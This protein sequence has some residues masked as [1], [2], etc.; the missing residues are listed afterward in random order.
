MIDWW[1]HMYYNG[2]LKYDTYSHKNML[3][4]I[5][6]FTK[7]LTIKHVPISSTLFSFVICFMSS[8]SDNQ[9]PCCMKLCYCY[10]LMLLA[11]D[12]P[13]NLSLLQYEVGHKSISYFSRWSN[14]SV[15]TLTWF[16]EGQILRNND[17]SVT[18]PFTVAL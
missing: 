12:Y 9:S 6:R 13:S 3:Q 18:L 2:N 1:Q 17:W 4:Q 7:N 11:F 16:I 15:T 14:F 8:K 5:P 10:W